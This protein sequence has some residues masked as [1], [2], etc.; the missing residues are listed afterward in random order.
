[1]TPIAVLRLVFGASWA[2]PDALFWHLD[3][4]QCGVRLG[5]DH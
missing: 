3:L 4:A 2:A 5:L 1:M